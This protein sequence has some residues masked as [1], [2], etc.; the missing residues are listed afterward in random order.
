MDDFDV[1]SDMDAAYYRIT[2]P[3]TQTGQTP[4]PFCSAQGFNSNSSK[5]R[6]KSTPAG[7]L[8][9]RLSEDRILVLS[10]DA[11]RSTP[12]GKVEQ[13]NKQTNKQKNESLLVY[14]W[15]ILF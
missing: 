11:A 13:T 8:A 3:I 2:S 10:P 15:N 9:R 14:M 7:N 1:C 12:Q 4:S 5:S 6:Q